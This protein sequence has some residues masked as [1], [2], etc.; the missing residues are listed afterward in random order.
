[1]CLKLLPYFLVLPWMSDPQLLYSAFFF[2]WPMQTPLLKICFSRYEKM[3]EFGSIK[4]LNLKSNY[5]KAC[6]VSYPRAQSAS[7]L[8]S[9]PSSAQGVLQVSSFSGSCFTPY[10]GWWQV[11]NFS[12]QR[13]CMVINS[14][15]VLRGISW[16]I[17]PT[18]LGMS[19]LDL[20][21]ISL[22]IGNSMCYYW[23]RPS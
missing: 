9:T 19:F 22:M 17:C 3:Q 14:T 1:M 20:A 21:N 4:I 16:P 13:S 8:V 11:P 10:R 18:V 7:L 23:T 2:K 15:I 12:S 5:L 6:S